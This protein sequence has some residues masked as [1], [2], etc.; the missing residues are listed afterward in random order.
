M[1]ENLSQLTG[2]CDVIFSL[3]PFV[4]VLCRREINVFGAWVVIGCAS[5]CWGTGGG[6]VGVH[7]SGPQEEACRLARP[8]CIG[9]LSREVRCRE[10]RRCR[11]SP[12]ARVPV[13]FQRGS[14]VGDV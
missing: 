13:G 14:T 7:C 4:G 12:G 1:F 6:I 3:K 10:V 5:S 11:G 8:C 2:V 9:T